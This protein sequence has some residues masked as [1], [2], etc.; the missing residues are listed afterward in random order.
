VSDT[1]RAVTDKVGQVIG[2][3]TRL[4]IKD[5]AG[6]LPL[7]QI[8]AVADRI[9]ESAAEEHEAITKLVRSVQAGD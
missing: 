3:M 2:A 4:Q 6:E 9:I 7:D 5:S 1:E 8:E